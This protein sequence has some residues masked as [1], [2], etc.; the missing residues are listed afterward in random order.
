LSNRNFKTADNIALKARVSS[1]SSEKEYSP[2]GAVDGIVDGYP[3]SRQAE[4]ASNHEKEGAWLKLEWEEE[5]TI[6]RIY[7]F[8]RPNLSDQVTSGELC[9]SDGTRESFGELPN[10]ASEGIELEFAPRKTDSIQLNITGVSESTKNSG[11]SEIVVFEEDSE[12]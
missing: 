9:F 4:W 1:S 7:L 10:D 3:G 11:I 2:K 12:E 8:D 5:Q 6:D